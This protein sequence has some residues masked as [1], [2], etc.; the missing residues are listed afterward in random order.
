MQEFQQIIED[1]WENRASLQPG[2]APAK[3]GE[4]VGKVIAA[5]D[6]GSLRVAEKIDGDW[7]THQWIKKAVLL[8][9]RLEDNVLMDNGPLRYFDKVPNKF[10]KYDTERFR[11]EGFR[12]VPPAAARRGSFIARNV[13]L[14]PS[15]VN[16]GAYVDEGSMVDTWATVGSCAQIGKNV[17]LSGGV[18]IGG[19][20]EPLQANPT[21]IEDN[22]F[23]GARSEVVEGVIVGEGSVI[24]MGVYIGQSTKIL[25]RE[26]GEVSYGRI[27]PGSVVVSGNLPSKDGSYSL[28]CAVIVKKVD[29][30]TRAKTSI[31]DLLRGD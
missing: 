9:F 21:I 31:N 26:T 12:V 16:I 25:D 22:C 24:S 6:A 14:M 4:A 18:G 5:L 30:K 11:R 15:Y 19:V 13:V 3:I 27:P 7:V 23:I 29:A 28:Y 20:L 1:A 17:H 10:A 8:S 2:T